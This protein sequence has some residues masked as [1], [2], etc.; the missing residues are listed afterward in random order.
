M[1][2]SACQTTRHRNAASFNLTSKSSMQ[3]T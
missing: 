3:V 1:V 2:F